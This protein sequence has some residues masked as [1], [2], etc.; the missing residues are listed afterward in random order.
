MKDTVGK[1]DFLV[2]NGIPTGRSVPMP[3]LFGKGWM[4]RGPYV[5][6]INAVM[7]FLIISEEGKR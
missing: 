1:E 4:R 6:V 7:P 3:P 5:F 2:H